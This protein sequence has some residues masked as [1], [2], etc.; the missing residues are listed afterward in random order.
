MMNITFKKDYKNNEKLRNSFNTLASM[1]FGI[2]FEKWY[3]L[4]LWNERYIPFSYVEGEQVIANVSVNLL[5]FVVNGKEK[6][7]IQI[8]TV[9]THPDYRNRGLSASLINKVLEEYGI[10]ENSCFPSIWYIQY[11]GPSDVL[12]Y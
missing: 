12:L 10:Q 4:G 2:N 1:V 5:D 6:K 3:K 11:A 8:G 9:M 7:A